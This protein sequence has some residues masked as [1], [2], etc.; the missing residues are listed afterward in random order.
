MSS[1]LQISDLLKVAK[2]IPILHTGINDTATEYST[3]PVKEHTKLLS[4][5]GKPAST[6]LNSM[7]AM[8]TIKIPTDRN[9]PNYKDRAL[10]ETYKKNA[11]TLTFRGTRTAPTSTVEWEE[12]YLH[13]VP[14]VVEHPKILLSES[15]NLTNT[16]T[17]LY[18]A[19]N[20][21]IGD[22][23]LTVEQRSML[24]LKSLCLPILA[25][26][27]WVPG[28]QEDDDIEKIVLEEMS[29]VA[30]PT[31]VD[32]KRKYDNTV[33]LY[34]SA[35][36]LLRELLNH[37]FLRAVYHTSS[38]QAQNEYKEVQRTF[39][40]KNSVSRNPKVFTA[41]DIID[42]ITA[43]CT[44]DNSKAI[45][46][47]K[48]S[49]AALIRYKGQNLVSWFQTFQP[50]VNKYKKAIG[51]GTTL[52]DDELKALWKEHF[53]KQ[54]TVAERT[55][56]KTFQLAHLGTQDVAKISKLSDGKF[57]DTVLY[58]LA[59]VLTTS[60]ESYNPDNTVM[61]YL[62]QHAQALRWEHK[63]DFRPPKEK[64]K[65]QN[66]DKDKEDGRSQK[67]KPK[68]SRKPDG[69]SSS[70]KK[71]RMTDKRVPNPKRIKS[72][73][74]C[75]RQ[76]CR[77]RGTNTNHTHS[78]CKFKESEPH[79][80]FGTDPKKHPNLG[81]APGKKPR[82]TKTTSSQPEKNA[83]TSQ[84]KETGERKCYIC[85]QPGHLANACPSKGKIK[86]GAQ[87]S[88][89]KNK[90]FMALWQSSFADQE[91]QQCATRLLKSWG[92]DVC[93]TCMGELSFDHRCDTND[94]AIAKHTQKVRDVLRTT[95]LLDTIRSAHEYQRES[96]EKPEPINMGPDFFLDARGQDESDNESA[97][98]DTESQ[99]SSSEHEDDNT[100]Q[101][102]SENSGDDSS[103]PPSPSDDELEEWE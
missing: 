31:D 34:Q 75:R 63:L 85:N 76:G 79:T 57:D 58:R 96:T 78:D 24:K 23:S 14:L 45:I 20:D 2:D 42:Y 101:D 80:K 19:S 68:S 46:Q 56:M 30:I 52:D 92:D 36:T 17:K 89:Y 9:D 21:F 69:S 44:C 88:L 62:K 73:D 7:L 6:P 84:I 53:A 16:M 3:Y 59:S 28:S 72:S 15:K 48:N 37:T 97:K 95:P 41:V 54:I 67:R 35:L 4:S 25:D 10:L 60:F 64:E 77:D 13:L 5:S 29:L 87:N 71:L 99:R 1:S 8:R 39:V 65:E 61:T 94:V 26:N 18:R 22:A 49:I 81:K 12:F 66:R 91:Q 51:L 33:V 47:M 70:T 83:S 103:P 82:N 40:T 32:E 74:H 43:N 102:H 11:L 98:D 55:V 27:P 90:S 100:E 93:P 50:L 38:R 86:A